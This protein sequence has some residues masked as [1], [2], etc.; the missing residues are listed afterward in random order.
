M[1]TNSILK[2]CCTKMFSFYLKLFE[3]NVR[4]LNSNLVE[5]KSVSVT[6]HTDQINNV[7][8]TLEHKHCKLC[9][10]KKKSDCDLISYFYVGQKFFYFDTIQ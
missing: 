7:E 3:C 6:W 10:L 1:Y 5:S 2:T 9:S 8:D 4:K